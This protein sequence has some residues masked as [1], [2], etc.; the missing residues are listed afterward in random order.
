[1]KDRK[2]ELKRVAIGDKL[3][4]RWVIMGV[5][6]DT[7]EVFSA[8]PE[9]GALDGYQTWRKGQ[10]HAKYLRNA[11]NKNAR[12]PSENELSV[13]YNEVVEA[14][15]NNNAKFNTSHYH[16]ASNYWS[17][18]RD[19]YYLSE[20][21]VQCLFNGQLLSRR[22]GKACARVRCVRDEPGLKLA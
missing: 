1:M 6:P 8:E 13:I 10:K 16:P 9:A 4:D 12:Q 2:D 14:G 20:A 3:P 21:Y 19:M 18:T 17:S 7:G 15:C 11:G 5:S 22:K